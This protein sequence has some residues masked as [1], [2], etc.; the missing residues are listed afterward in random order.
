MGDDASIDDDM[1]DRIYDCML[2]RVRDKFPNVRS[3]AI[4]AL[5]RLQDPQ[6]PECPVIS[7]YLRIMQIDKSAEVRRAAL[8]NVALSAQTLPFIIGKHTVTTINF[9]L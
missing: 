7:S 4:A 3:Q 9:V 8:L 1:A 5:A 2:V 6:D